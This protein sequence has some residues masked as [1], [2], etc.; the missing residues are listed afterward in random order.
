M[1]ETE[2]L[3]V[4]SLARTQGETIVNELFILR[5][6]SSL[7]DLRAAVSGIVEQRMADIIH[8]DTDLVRTTGFQTAFHD[9]DIAETLDDPVM[10]DRMLALVPFRIYLEAK[11]VIRIAA[12]VAGD[13]PL[14]FFK[15]P[16]NHGHILPLYRMPEKLPRQ[17]ELRLVI[18]R[19]HQ[20]AGG[21]HV[22]AMDQYAHAF[23]LGILPLRNPE[24]I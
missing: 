3:G 13:G 21:V 14:V 15:I 11:S 9:R 7:A 4:E 1:H 8:V 19:Y 17:I 5:V 12:D 18:L 10:S 24:M 16:P 23:V 22:N 6:D 20:K 2:G